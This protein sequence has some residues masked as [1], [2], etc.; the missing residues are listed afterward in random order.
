MHFSERKPIMVLDN[1]Y[2]PP[3]DS[4][5]VPRPINIQLRQLRRTPTN[6]LFEGEQPQAAHRFLKQQQL[7]LGK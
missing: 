4:R 1:T 7:H 5:T 3:N 6:D 2:T